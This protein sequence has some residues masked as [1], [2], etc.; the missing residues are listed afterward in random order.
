MTGGLRSGTNGESSRRDKGT[1]DRQGNVVLAAEGK[2]ARPGGRD[3]GALTFVLQEG[4]Q[5]DAEH[6]GEVVKERELDEGG[7][8]AGEQV[9]R[10]VHE[11]EH[12]PAVQQEDEHRVQEV[13]VVHQ[14][15]HPAVREH[16]LAQ[17]QTRGKVKGAAAG[18][19]AGVLGG[20]GGGGGGAATLPSGRQPGALHHAHQPTH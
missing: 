10:E 16:P 7:G 4:G 3:G 11:R 9:A 12:G 14:R 20:R 5:D 8:A 15:V 2:R 17:R 13:V 18:G 19:Q 6:G 1:G